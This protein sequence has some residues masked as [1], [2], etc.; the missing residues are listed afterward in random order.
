MRN[1]ADFLAGL[2]E[3]APDAGRGDYVFTGP[4]GS[5]L[6]V[7]QIIIQSD[8]Q[9]ALHRIWTHRPGNGS[10]TIMLRALCRLADRHGVEIKLKVLPIGRKPY[11]M[12]RQ[13]LLAWYQRHGFEGSGWKL[14]RLPQG[15][16]EEMAC[17]P[18]PDPA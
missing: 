2:R 7:V 5:A 11:P 17:G 4:D 6:G 10:G 8:R 13:Q 15:A 18:L 12:S 9:V 14:S 3:I 16:A 1:V